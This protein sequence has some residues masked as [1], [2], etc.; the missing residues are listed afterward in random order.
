MGI[1]KIGDGSPEAAAKFLRENGLL[2]EINR[3]VLHPLGLALEIVVEIDDDTGEETGVVSMGGMWDYRM[4]HE[5]IFFAPE[6][7]KSGEAKYNAYIRRRGGRMMESRKEQL[8]FV[9]QTE[10]GDEEET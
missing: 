2:F 4:D 9:V 1:N 6:S 7:F 3:Q 10:A 8:G 5:G